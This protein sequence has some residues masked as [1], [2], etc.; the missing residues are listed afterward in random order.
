MF[1][2]FC[3]KEIREEASMCIHCG[4]LTETSAVPSFSDFN[5]RGLSKMEVTLPCPLSP[6]EIDARMLNLSKFGVLF[7]VVGRNILRDGFEYS[8]TIDMGLCSFGELMYIRS[9]HTNQGTLVN[10]F[11]KCVFPLQFISWGKHQRNIA[12]IKNVLEMR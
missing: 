11:S 4:S 9:F 7:D 6:K 2:K 10:I 12:K 1:C 8:L 3:G 5:K